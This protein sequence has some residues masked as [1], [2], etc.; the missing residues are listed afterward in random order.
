MEAAFRLLALQLIPWAFQSCRTTFS[1]LCFPASELIRLGCCQPF[2]VCSLS[3]GTDSVWRS[4]YQFG[5]LS[6]LIFTDV[7]FQVSS[8]KGFSCGVLLIH[9][10]TCFDPVVANIFATDSFPEG[11]VWFC[12]TSSESVNFPVSILA[13]GF[14]SVFLPDW[15]CLYQTH[16]NQIMFC[17][18]C[19]HRDFCIFL[20]IKDRFYF[21]FRIRFLLPVASL[22]FPFSL[23]LKSELSL[24]DYCKSK[25]VLISLLQVSS[26]LIP[27]LASWFTTILLTYNH[28][29]NLFPLSCDS[30]LKSGFPAA[31]STVVLRFWL[32]RV[33][34]PFTLTKE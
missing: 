10:R 1:H 20:V 30:F 2:L 12:N 24:S 31:Q 11:L 28:L 32:I 25:S 16:S 15:A 29:K 22:F 5:C 19:C 7:F 4:C 34:V 21:Q 13:V 3:R 14:F 17:S 18:F 8:L 27:A 26:K 6:D 33:S 23:S 9:T